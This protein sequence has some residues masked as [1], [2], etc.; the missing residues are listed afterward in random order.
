MPLPVVTETVKDPIKE[1]DTTVDE[2]EV[3]VEVTEEWVLGMV[4]DGTQDT[5]NLA[6]PIFLD[7]IETVEDQEETK[8]T[9]RSTKASR[10]HE[11]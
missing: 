9:Q 2:P 5:V 6:A 1:I 8:E 3:S 4:I 10:H 11:L 7:L